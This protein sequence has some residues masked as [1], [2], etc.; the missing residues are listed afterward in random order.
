MLR[1]AVTGATGFIGK[2][3]VAELCKIANLEIL[4]CGRSESK[5]ALLQ[6]QYSLH[7]L[8]CDLQTS[9]EDWFSFLG[10]PDILIH[11][12]WGH[13]GQFQSPAHRSE[14]LGIHAN[15]I[16]KMIQS[17]LQSLTVAGTCFE[18]GIQDGC[19][20]EE[21]PIRPVTEYGIAKSELYQLLENTLTKYSCNFKWLRYFYMYGEGQSPRTLLALLDSAIDRG[22]TTFPMSGGLQIRDYLPVETVAHYTVQA[23]LQNKIHGAINVCSGKPISILDLVTERVAMRRSSIV[24]D[25]SYY[26]YADYEPM[27]FWGDTKKL[28]QLEPLGWMPYDR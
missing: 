18:Y 9:R 4:A 25:T 27:K 3:V 16:V 26:P 15:F 17:G 20:C 1:I 13:L 21:H 28:H 22:D 7:T 12:A 6:S 14:E 2:K 23:A 24:L 8:C 11:L 19:L 5:L 10:S